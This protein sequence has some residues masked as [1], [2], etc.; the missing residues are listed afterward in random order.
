VS[1]SLPDNLVVLVFHMTEA[2]LPVF[3][4][5]YHR[6]FELYNYLLFN[7]FLSLALLSLRDAL[8]QINNRS[9]PQRLLLFRLDIVLPFSYLRYFSP[10]RKL[11]RSMMH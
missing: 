1:F 6:Y 3:D 10:L 5:R 8:L 11:H 4:Y 2:I 9:Q 7:L